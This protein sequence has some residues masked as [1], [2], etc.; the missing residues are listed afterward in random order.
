MC[1]HVHPIPAA[2]ARSSRLDCL[3]ALLLPVLGGLSPVSTPLLLPMSISAA[4][5][6]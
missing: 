4:D 1:A 2:A 5:D 6:S 3:V